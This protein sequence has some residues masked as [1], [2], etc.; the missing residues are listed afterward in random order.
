[1]SRSRCPDGFTL[2]ELA[3][4]LLVL[5][6]LA[7]SLALPLAGRL[8]ARRFEEAR[9]QLDGVRDALLA[10]AAAHGRLPCPA[11]EASRGE[12]RFAPGGGP[13]D[14]ECERFHDGFLPAATLGLSPVDDQGFVRDPW[15]SVAN[16]VRYAVAATTV[17]GTT[18]AFT[19]RH[20]A[21]QA[22]L[23][24]L[25]AADRFLVVCATAEGSGAGGCG[26]AAM[27]L[28]RKAV[29]VIHSAGPNASSPE[30]PPPDERRNREGGPVF[31]ARE[32]VAGT[33]RDFDDVVAWAGLSQLTH[34]LLAAG[35]LP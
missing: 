22:T 15:G 1:M 3:L 28:T 27:Q 8:E 7:G 34:S 35:R 12:E 11:T 20:G 24:G 18:R 23:A 32:P 13:A 33:A 25:A 10:Y 2:L 4:A 5:G 21:S 14:G 26:T 29:F 17:N 16:R 31:V 30:T 6:L 19:R 9:R